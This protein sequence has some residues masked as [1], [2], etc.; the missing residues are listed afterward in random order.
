MDVVYMNGFFMKFVVT[1]F[2]WFEHTWWLEAS[3]CL[4]MSGAQYRVSLYQSDKTE[5]SDT[6]IS[7]ICT[8]DTQKIKRDMHFWTFNMDI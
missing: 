7:L 4:I 2:L 8:P 1:T 5:E 6:I 3:A